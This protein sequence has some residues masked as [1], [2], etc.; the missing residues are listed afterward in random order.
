MDTDLI[1]TIGIITLVL[2]LPSLLAAWVDGRPPRVGA[3]M[4]VTGIGMIV[5]AL[6]TNPGGYAFS[7]VPGIMLAVVTRAF[8]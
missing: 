6:M 8:N 2:S 7:D 4:C 5:A 3:I 1:L